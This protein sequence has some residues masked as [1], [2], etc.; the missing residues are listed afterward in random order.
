MIMR[1]L[2]L[3]SVCLVASL[4]AAMKKISPHFE[5]PVGIHAEAMKL[6]KGKTVSGV[7]ENE[8][9]RS[10]IEALVQPLGL[11]LVV[12]YEMVLIVPDND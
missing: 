8:K 2:L 11:K 1:H 12:K 6:A 3:I 5:L 7:I 4:Q 10:T 9:L